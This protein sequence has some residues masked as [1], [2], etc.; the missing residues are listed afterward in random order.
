MEAETVRCVFCQI[1]SQEAPAV[2]VYE[3][4]E[5]IAFMDKAPFNLGHTLVLPKRHY[6]FLTD[7]SNSEVG[8]LFTAV[9]RVAKAI[10]QATGADGLNIAQSNGEAASQDILHVHV[11][12]VPRFRGDSDDGFFPPRKHPDAH[13]VEESASRIRKKLDDAKS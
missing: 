12:I 9:S 6:A 11:H 1:I 4:D 2:Q 5:I 3:D 8:R 10:S 7:M 13:E